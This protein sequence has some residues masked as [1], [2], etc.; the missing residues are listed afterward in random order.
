MANK[1]P[2]NSY[3]KIIS[4]RLADEIDQRYQLLNSASQCLQDGDFVQCYVRLEGLGLKLDETLERMLDQN[5]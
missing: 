4:G 3:Q 5:D 2:L 1:K